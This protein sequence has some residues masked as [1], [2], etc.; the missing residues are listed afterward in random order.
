LVEAHV[1]GDLL[2]PLLAGQL[3]ARHPADDGD[4]V[5]RLRERVAG[6]PVLRILE[7]HVEDA[8]H[9]HG[10]SSLSAVSGRNI[11]A[12]MSFSAILP[13]VERPVTEATQE[14][15][16]DLVRLGPGADERLVDRPGAAAAAGR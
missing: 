16:E 2:L 11:I 14:R 7:V 5:T 4:L 13:R 12:S 6:P 8:C 10:D 1:G 9:T 3:R 15:V